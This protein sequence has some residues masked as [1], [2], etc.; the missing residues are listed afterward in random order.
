MKQHWETIFD[1]LVEETPG[2]RAARLA[3]IAAGDAEL[4]RF[5]AELLA[6]DRTEEEFIGAPL[7]ARA[8]VFVASA[9][10]SGVA[11]MEESAGPE[12]EVSVIEAEETIGPYRLVR[13]LGEGGMGEVFLAERSDGEFEQRVALKRIRAGLESSAIAE[14]FLRER[15][16]LARLEHPG[17]AHLLEDRK[18]TRLNSSH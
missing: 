1:E 11:R 10:E 5:L 18:S 6:A 15:Q 2:V 14:R 12:A 3:E 4:A 7:L 9:L 16:I 17:I 8:P 13:C